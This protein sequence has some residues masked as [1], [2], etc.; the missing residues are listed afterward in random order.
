M[1]S[2]LLIYAEHFG[3][4]DRAFSLLPDPEY[5]YWSTEHSR[6]YSML[7]Y[8][9]LTNASI[10]VIT[11]EI[12]SG[13][14]TLIRHLLR[15]VPGDFVIGLI[16][17]A[18]GDRGQLLQWILLALGQPVDN[19][20]SYVQLFSQFQDFLIS[21]YASGKRTVLIFDEAQNLS[22]A[23]LEELRMLSNINADKDELLQ[24]VLVGQPQ[25]RD[26]INR[27]E[28]EQFSQRVAADFHLPA[29]TAENVD[30]YIT[31]RLHVAGATAEIFT[32][33]ARQAVFHYSRGIPRLINKLC[34][35]ALVYA[36]SDNQL[37][38][39]EDLIHKVAAD[40][41][42]LGHK[43]FGEA[44][45][46]PGESGPKKIHARA[47]ALARKGYSAE[48]IRHDLAERFGSTMPHAEII[49]LLSRLHA[50][51][52]K[53]ALRP[54]QHAYSLIRFET[55][56]IRIQGKR[57]VSRK[58]AYIVL[59]LDRQGDGC[60]LDLSIG[61]VVGP[62]T[63]EAIMK[64]LKQRGLREARL[65]SIEGANGFRDAAASAFPDAGF[66]AA[67][68]QLAEL[69]P[70]RLLQSEYERVLTGLVA[71]C[72]GAGEADTTPEREAYMVRWGLRR[73]RSRNK[74]EVD[75]G[76]L[77]ALAGEAFMEEAI[78]AAIVLKPFFR[79]IDTMVNTEQIYATDEAAMRRF[80][81]ELLKVEERK[82]IRFSA[83]RA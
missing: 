4:R 83:L 50:A 20:S 24:I 3:L 17:N 73:T 79:S 22:V 47:M 43:E 28:L 8:G 59:A 49:D 67:F 37:A 53:W 34:E 70:D 62:R 31:H 48:A 7:E 76:A 45:A 68:R 66:V 16:S 18:Q 27:P 54:L 57:E 42:E 10:T 82:S 12:G 60:V 41:K 13:K 15:N 81:S 65:V 56:W 1:S 21:T 5:L 14:T 52:R 11:G 33:A 39:D 69:V 74:G 38:I 25:L 36:F 58:A 29:M 46:G 64:S 72:E 35:N 9:L 40:W 75:W 71:L 32:P 19:N 2:T 30:R 55:I 63:Y 44:R 78:R 61:Q 77:H 6:A 23:T 51:E 26:L 80:C